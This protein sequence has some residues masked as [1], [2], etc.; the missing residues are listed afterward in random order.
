MDKSD[1]P[2]ACN[3]CHLDQTLAWAAEKMSN[4]YG[5]PMPELKTEEKE[6][7]ASLLWLLRGDAT[8]RAITAWHMN[9]D[10]ALKTSGEQWQTPFLAKTLV[11]DYAAVRYL[12][13]QALRR[14]PEF[15]QLRY[16]Y[17][18]PAIDRQAASKKLLELWSNREKA[19]ISNSPQLLIDTQTLKLNEERVT[20]ILNRQ[21]K[22][23]TSLPE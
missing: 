12:A 5:K 13:E 18:G 10:A 4:W 22:R 6:V 7:A 9:W 16:D 11:D 8:Q 19:A 3:L 2:N 20:D 14:V 21:D 23:P 15:K 17:I 1:H